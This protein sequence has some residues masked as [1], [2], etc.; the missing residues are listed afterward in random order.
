MVV[1]TTPAGVLLR[2][3]GAERRVVCGLVSQQRQAFN[4]GVG[5]CLEAV[6]NTGRVPSKFECWKLLT[7]ARGRGA[8]AS[9]APL[10]IQ[11]PGVASGRES[12]KK[13]H[14]AR[15]SHDNKVA[16]WTARL[17]LV[18]CDR[19]YKPE[20]LYWETHLASHPTNQRFAANARYWRG[21]V[22]RVEAAAKKAGVRQGARKKAE[23]PDAE[24]AP[25]EPADA[26]PA[27]GAKRRRVDLAAEEKHCRSRL[28]RAARKRDRHRSK[29]TRRLFRSRKA[30]H[31]NPARLPALTVTEGARLEPDAVVLPGG[32]RLPF[33]EPWTVPDGHGWTGA[34]QIVD[35]TRR[36]TSRTRPEHRKFV[37]RPQLHMTTPAASEPSCADEVVGIDAGVVVTVAVS[38][39]RMLDLPDEEDVNTQIADAKRSRSRC[40]HGSRQWKQRT[41]T[42]SKLYRRRNHKRDDAT[43]HIA[44]Q[45]ATTAAVK[46]V[47]AEITNTVAMT[48]SAAGTVK[49]PGTNVAQKRGLNRSLADRRFGGVRTAVERACAKAGTLYVGV[50]AAGTSQICHRCGTLGQRETQALFRCAEP[51]GCG[52]EG[53]A[54]HNS[55]NTVKHRTWSTFEADRKTRRSGGSSLDGGPEGNSGQRQP[56][57]ALP[58]PSPR[59]TSDQLAGHSRI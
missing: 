9:G 1:Y 58:S 51:Q 35:T 48:A 39:G 15:I 18:L 32:T 13:W 12:V 54:D 50:A 16:Y 56:T 59:N 40:D 52:W 2:L 34:V 53:N 27:A 5:V 45:V 6:E 33:D 8:M 31:A 19:R 47:G 28:D 17:Q 23:P 14:K 25:A 3:S 57:T 41:R 26:E 42:I 46:A 38:D 22:D 4:F 37:M 49:H 21:V 11:R 7:A 43:R 24:P 36:V 29:G 44:K 10:R 55:A 30:Q 20:A